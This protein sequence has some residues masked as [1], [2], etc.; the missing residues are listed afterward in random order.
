MAEQIYL[1]GVHAGWS[2]D[3]DST[4]P[5]LYL[6]GHPSDLIYQQTKV[7]LSHPEA[8][9]QITTQTIIDLFTGIYLAASA[10]AM[11]FTEAVGLDTN[12]MYSIISEAAGS[13]AQF[14]HAVPQMRK[15]SWSVA[16]VPSAKAI[17]GRL[18]SI[19]PFTTIHA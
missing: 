5:R 3:D 15:P 8:E 1:S 12:T 11:G 19:S 14:V 10:E 2:K 16:D 9:T 17:A 4:L 13:S 18:V 7:T 6:Q